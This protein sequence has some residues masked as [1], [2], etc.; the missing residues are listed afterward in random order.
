MVRVDIHDTYAEQ[1]G[2][3]N[4]EAL[5]VYK[6]RLLGFSK[7]LFNVA[8]RLEHVDWNKGTFNSTGKKH[9]R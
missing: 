8:V 5:P 4:M 6:K 7:S 9:N 1:L 3:S 2:E